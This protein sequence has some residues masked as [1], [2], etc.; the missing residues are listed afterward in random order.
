VLSSG[1]IH[2]QV[3]SVSLLT[4]EEAQD[5]HL[6]TINARVVREVQ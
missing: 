4:M 6:L 1:L 3:Q 5:H 2:L